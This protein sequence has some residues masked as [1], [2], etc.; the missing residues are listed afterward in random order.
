MKA[1]DAKHSWS[2]M[3]AKAP[4]LPR[5]SR[6]KSSPKR[7][8]AERQIGEYRTLNQEKNAAAFGSFGSYTVSLLQ[9]VGWRDSLSAG[10]R[11][12]AFSRSFD[13]YR[14]EENSRGRLCSAPK[15]FK[16]VQGAPQGFPPEN[17]C[18]LVSWPDPLCIHN[19]GGSTGVKATITE[20]RS[21]STFRTVYQRKL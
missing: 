11:P 17:R 12:F 7:D 20:F 9:V 19:I 4:G 10:V 21:G 18:E 14:E 3:T 13:R 6:R 15:K 8:M 16:E 2:F 1:I 5:F